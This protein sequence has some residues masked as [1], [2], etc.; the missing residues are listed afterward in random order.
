MSNRVLKNVRTNPVTGEQ[1]YYFPLEVTDDSVLAYAKEHN[2]EIGLARLGYRRFRAV[3]VPCRDQFTDSHGRVTFI[4]TPSDVQRRRYLDLIKDEMNAQED[5]KQ[6]GRCDIPDGHGGTKRCPCR[7]ANPDYIP[8]GDKPK[9]LPVRCEGC[10]YERYKQAHTVIE[11]SCLDHEGEDGEMEAYDVPAPRSNYA[12][13]RYE[14][15]ADEF[16]AFVRER[17]PRLAPLAEKLV[18]EY[19]KSDAGRELG[20]PTSTVTSRADKLK[21]LLEEFLDNAIIF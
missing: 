4:D 2:L 7:T 10:P 11:L 17:K 19:T 5:I 16:V 6:D 1:D 18:Q 13:D 21:E 14:E 9:T 15:L 3:F 8:G 20:L 12:G